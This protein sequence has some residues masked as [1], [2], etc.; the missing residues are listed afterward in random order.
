V[1]IVIIIVGTALE[2]KILH[3]HLEGYN[4]YAQQVR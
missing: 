4:D 1:G 2:D 3:Q